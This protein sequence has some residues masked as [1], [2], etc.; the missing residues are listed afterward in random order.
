MA[1]VQQV[2]NVDGVDPADNDDND[3][4]E[5]LDEKKLAALI[6]GFKALIQLQ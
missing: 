3:L 5:G 2:P 6:A 1:H 4:G